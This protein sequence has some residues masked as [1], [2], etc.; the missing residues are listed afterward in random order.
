[1]V[2]APASWI[3]YCLL[4]IGRVQEEKWQPPQAQPLANP[5]FLWAR[6]SLNVSLFCSCLLLPKPGHAC[7]SW[8]TWSG[9]DWEGQPL[10]LE[11]PVGVGV[12]D[13]MSAATGEGEEGTTGWLVERS[14]QVWYQHSWQKDVIGA[15]GAQR[16]G[17]GH[18]SSYNRAWQGILPGKK[19]S[20]VC[21]H[22]CQTVSVAL[23][24]R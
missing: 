2:S 20:E 17:K 5:F 23:V 4:G 1:M 3:K 13:E 10:S 12:L 19:A 18:V 11:P 21:R 9:A 14:I 15:L 7:C 22:H 16:I 24:R 8:L 6:A